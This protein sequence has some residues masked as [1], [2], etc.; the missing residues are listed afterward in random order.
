VAE[1]TLA[2]LK[3]QER[4]ADAHRKYLLGAL[5]DLANWGKPNIEIVDNRIAEIAD[6]LLEVSKIPEYR[7]MGELIFE[8]A[9][10]D[11]MFKKQRESFPPDTWKEEV[12]YRIT[13]G[14][15]W[16]KYNLGG[17]SK[18]VLLGAMVSMELENNEN[19]IK[20]DNPVSR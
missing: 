1:M 15:V 16:V 4:S 19:C 10:K 13:I 17:V 18:A 9:K 12:H 6:L 7:K 20:P 11:K 14:G 3:K 5:V 8:K 2:R